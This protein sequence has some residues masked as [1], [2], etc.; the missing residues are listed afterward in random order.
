[1][2]PLSGAQGRGASSDTG[3]VAVAVDREAAS[4]DTA[5]SALTGRHQPAAREHSHLIWS[6]SRAFAPSFS[7]AS[8]GYRRFMKG[9][10]HE[11]APR[12]PI[13]RVPPQ[14]GKETRARHWRDL[15]AEVT[16]RLGKGL[17]WA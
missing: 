13:A 12:S 5:G 10:C 4:L 11:V 1:A 15:T 2:A 3:F 14:T 16:K 8:A 17:A 9:G 7:L 6:E